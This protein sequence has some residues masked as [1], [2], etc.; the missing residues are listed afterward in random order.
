MSE[1][2]IDPHAIPF[3]V[4]EVESG[5]HV[6]SV[7]SSNELVTVHLV[8][9]NV[10]VYMHDPRDGSKPYLVIDIDNE[11]ESDT[12]PLELRIYRNDAPVY[13]ET[14]TQETPK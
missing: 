2:D 1:F 12:D 5:L 9:C 14:S 6:P 7:R 8:E 10:A 3:T 13:I 4:G 11:L